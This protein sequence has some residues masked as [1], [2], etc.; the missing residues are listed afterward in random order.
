MS[1]RKYAVDT[2]G[3]MWKRVD[4]FGSETYEPATYYG[5]TVAMEH[6]GPLNHD[7]VVIA[8]AGRVRDLE[9]RLNEHVF[10][11]ESEV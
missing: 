8:L 5:P 4:T 7:P 10:Y 9:E 2:N 3:D 1:A 6:L 11:G